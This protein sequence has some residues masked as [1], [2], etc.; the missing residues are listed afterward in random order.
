MLLALNCAAV[1]MMAGIGWLVQLVAYPLFAE[2]GEAEFP[3]FHAEWSR[4]IGI[5]VFAPMSVDL[6]TSI[7]LAVSPPEGVATA[8]AIAGAVLAAVTWLSTAF[9][10]VPCHERLS[11]GFDSQVHARLLRTSWVR[12]VAWSAHGAICVVM[13]SQAAG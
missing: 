13:L 11:A 1:L 6:V 12:T 7:W 3:R 2:V 8:L 10:Q 5:V 9:L 4:R